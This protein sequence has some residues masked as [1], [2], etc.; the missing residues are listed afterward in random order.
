MKEKTKI[1]Y[2]K[3]PDAAF[4]G[5]SSSS[6]SI[7]GPTRYERTMIPFSE[8]GECQ[9]EYDGVGRLV[10]YEDDFVVFDMRE[11]ASLTPCGT[12]L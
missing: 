2:E 11:R 12:S 3:L 1:G 10:Y 9:R 6:S 4:L 5:W 8:L 7:S